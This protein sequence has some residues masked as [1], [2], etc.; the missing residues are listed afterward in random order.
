VAQLERMWPHHQ[1]E[2][3]L[4]SMARQGRQQL[5]ELFA[6]ERETVKA[7]QQDDWGRH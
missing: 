3:A 1:D 2:Q 7:R 5:E 6:Q 4:V